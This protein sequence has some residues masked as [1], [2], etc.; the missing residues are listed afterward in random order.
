M[1]VLGHTVDPAV[2]TMT[3]IWAQAVVATTGCAFSFV[4][5]GGMAAYLYT[6]TEMTCPQSV[7]FEDGTWTDAPF[8]EWSRTDQFWRCYLCSNAGTR[9][10][11]DHLTGNRHLSRTQG[12]WNQLGQFTRGRQQIVRVYTDYNYQ[13]NQP[14]LPAPG[15]EPPQPAGAP[16]APAAAPPAP[17]AAAQHTQT[18]TDAL[19]QHTQTI[20]DAMEQIMETKTEH[21]ERIERKFDDVLERLQ[22][23]ADR[24][25][26]VSDR[27]AETNQLISAAQPRGAVQAVRAMQGA[28]APP[29]AHQ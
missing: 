2:A 1:G 8:M 5:C 6:E 13:Q 3:A 26:L 4:E 16:P 23:V 22:V 27:L 17:A 11:A 18:I 25:A 10:T 7:M 19:E 21:I 24:L 15:L 20:T 12:Q 29:R 9:V 14:A 28:D